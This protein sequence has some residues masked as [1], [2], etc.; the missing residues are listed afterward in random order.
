METRGAWPSSLRA[1]LAWLREPRGDVQLRE[2][3]NKVKRDG[4]RGVDRP[5][6]AGVFICDEYVCPGLDGRDRE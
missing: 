3:E 2:K 5:R 4:G 1:R 6:R